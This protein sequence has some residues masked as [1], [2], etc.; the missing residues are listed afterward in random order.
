MLCRIQALAL[1]ESAVCH[2][3]DFAICNKVDSVICSKVK[4]AVCHKA[5]SRFAVRSAASVGPIL[6]PPAH[7][8]TIHCRANP[9]LLL[10][11]QEPNIGQATMCPA[12][13]DGQPSQ[14]VTTPLPT[15]VPFSR[16]PGISCQG[17]RGASQDF[18]FPDNKKSP[19]LA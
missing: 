10:C 11:Q 7:N 16:Y 12:P 18:L 4:S 2:R 13:G 9:L 19:L 3:V 6:P 1:P 5:A 15:P 17:K 8:V 14:A